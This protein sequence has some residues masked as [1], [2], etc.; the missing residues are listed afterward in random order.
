L[1]TLKNDPPITAFLDL[2]ATSE[3][4]S[5]SPITL[6][7]G[8]DIIVT[9]VDGPHVFTDFST[10]PFARGREP[11]LVR[12]AQPALYKQDPITPSAPPVLIHG[13]IPALL[14]TAS[15]RYQITLPTWRELAERYKLGTFSPQAQDLAA[16]YLLDECH[17]TELIRSGNIEGAIRATNN[18]WASFPGNLY[19]QPTHDLSTLLSEYNLLLTRQ[20]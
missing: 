10:H 9:G 20:V 2:I 7:A 1:A 11:I 18:T 3:G 6:A 16:L 8:Y 5:R 4:T 15:G 12:A 19:G 17:A 13:P 14:S